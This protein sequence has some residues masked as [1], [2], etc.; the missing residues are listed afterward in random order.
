MGAKN[1]F[2]LRAR[3]ARELV[4]KKYKLS[5]FCEQNKLKTVKAI[6]H[7][8]KLKVAHILKVLPNKFWNWSI[9]LS[10]RSLN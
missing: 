1:L 5:K 10:D 2:W 9:A 4:L 8:G 6:N 3:K 7:E